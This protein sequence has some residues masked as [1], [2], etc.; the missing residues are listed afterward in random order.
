MN[1]FIQLLSKDNKNSIIIFIVLNIILVFFE[2]LSIA[3]IPLIIDFVISEKPLL[4]EYWSLIDNFYV[5]SSK[6]NLIL[7]ASIFIVFLFISKNI[8]I[9]GLVYYQETLKAKFRS[10]LKKIF[11][12]MY[13]SAPFEIINSYNSSKILR[14][15]DQE[16]SSYVSNFFLI[17]K[18]FK[19]FFL[20]LLILI[21][22]MSVNFFVTVI[23]VL[24]LIFLLILY[25]FL[26]HKKLHKFGEDGL[27]AK[28][29][30]I[31]WILQSLNTIKDIKISKKESKVLQK[32]IS[33]VDIFENSRKKISFIQAIPNSIFE[34]IF[35]IIIFT[36]II[37]MSNVQVENILPILSLYIISFIRLLPVFGKFGQI[38][39][40]L[41]SSYPSVLH[42]NSE[43]QKLEKFQN[44]KKKKINKS[45]DKIEFEKSLNINN[46]DFEYFNGDKK[47]FNNFNLS[48]KK[49]K[50]I[51]F[52]GKSGSGK[53]TLINI[54]S[55]LLSPT[56]GQIISDN[57]DILTN[58]DLWQKKIGL[59]PQDNFLL[60]D[61]ILKNIIF[62]DDENKIDK[63]RLENAIHYS[64]LSEFINELS[65]GINTSVGEGGAFLS[66]G[67]IQR[68]ILARVLYNDPEIL[69]LD[70]FTNSLDPKSEN[71]ILEKLNLLKIEK[72]KNLFIISHK[73]KPLKLCDEII[74]LEGGKIF[75]K[76]N[77]DEFYERFHFLY[78]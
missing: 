60:D 61:T 50:S 22:L 47:I 74:V 36:L 59:V 31:K 77:F 72:N 21:L 19:D 69:I 5:R 7:Y 16:T 57:V 51:G 33:K 63:N 2:T 73:M 62:L 14:N 13:L 29:S 39:S 37:F 3:I 12:T 35:V 58:I 32:F 41:R 42:L 25:F 48:I 26:F 65:L 64:S 71:H 28:N 30:L 38:I 11:F 20:F 40:A 70:E 6:N 75:K 17:L 24:I 8:Y 43:F 67:Q 15:T 9:L 76:Y 44:I 45:I 66:G 49:G 23:S 46:I 52:V 53:T 55:G 10:D 78:E 68:I 4:P 34:I 56:K 1:K 27:D 54:I 18:I